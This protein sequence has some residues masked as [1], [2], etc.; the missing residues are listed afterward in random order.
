[1]KLSLV[2]PAALLG[3]A[4]LSGP[5]AAQHRRAGPHPIADQIRAIEAQWNREW[6]QRDVARIAAHYSRDA[7]LMAPG[8]RMEGMTQIRAGIAQMVADPALSLTFHA[9]RVD[10]AASGDLAYTQG[11]Y[12]MRGTDPHSHQVTTDHGSYVTTYRRQRDGSWQAIDDIAS[13]GMTPGS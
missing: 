2:L 3:A 7:V 9:D 5:A 13:S 8:A 12:T 10:V 6:A 11:R 4:I 1:M